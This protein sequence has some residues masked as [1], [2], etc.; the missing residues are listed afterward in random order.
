M[1]KKDI[2]NMQGL[3]ESVFTEGA[4]DAMVKRIIAMAY[5]EFENGKF[6]AAK[7]HLDTLKGLKVGGQTI[8]DMPEYSEIVSGLESKIMGGATDKKTLD[9]R[10][11]EA[12]RTH[13]SPENMLKRAE[14]CIFTDVHVDVN[15]NSDLGRMMQNLH[16]KCREQ[17]PEKHIGHVNQPHGKYRGY[18]EYSCSCGYSD[19]TDS[20]D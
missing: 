1:N 8:A 7:D 12:H 3:Y 17:N 20:T 6:N 15:A 9:D 13:H 18:S 10:E 4:N 14:K 16:A 2:E 11:F 19:T 5:Q